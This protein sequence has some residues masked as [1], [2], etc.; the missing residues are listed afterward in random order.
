MNK[1]FIV[2]ELGAVGSAD[3]GA[4]LRAIDLVRAADIGHIVGEH[5]GR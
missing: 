4:L 5:L 2:A 1:P 3:S